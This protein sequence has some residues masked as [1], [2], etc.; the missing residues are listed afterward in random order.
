MITIYS[1]VTLDFLAHRRFYDEAALTGGSLRGLH[2]LA[3]SSGPSSPQLS[4]T[5]LSPGETSP[6]PQKNP[7]LIPASR[8]S[9]VL[10]H[11]G[12]SS[13]PST[14]HQPPAGGKVSSPHC[15]PLSPLRF[16]LQGRRTLQWCLQGSTL[17]SQ[18]KTE[19]S[20]LGAVG[21]SSTCH[22]SRVQSTVS[23]RYLLLAGK[24]GT[25]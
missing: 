4:F 10:P 11:A 24:L 13:S 16:L 17:G 20:V 18:V 15:H 22:S 7:T 23:L 12:L 6:P 8:G 9:P 14:R 3:G 2:S 1:H 25:S 5:W 19:H 21:V